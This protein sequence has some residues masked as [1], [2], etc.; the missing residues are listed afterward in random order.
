MSRPTLQFQREVV[1]RFKSVPEVQAIWLN[2]ENEHPGWRG[3]RFT[4]LVDP[5]GPDLALEAAQLREI[6]PDF[7]WDFYAPGELEEETIVIARQKLWERGELKPVLQQAREAFMEI[8]KV[9]D[10]TCSP[11]IVETG[12]RAFVTVVAR[13]GM[14]LPPPD[15]IN[16]V[17][18]ATRELRKKTP[19]IAEV[20]VA[21]ELNFPPTGIGVH[22]EDDPWLEVKGRVMQVVEPYRLVV[23]AWFLE[24][25]SEGANPTVY[26]YGDEVP[27]E[28][29]WDLGVGTQIVL[30]PTKDVPKAARCI[31]NPITRLMK[32]EAEGNKDE[33]ERIRRTIAAARE[34]PTS[35][36]EL[37]ELKEL[38]PADRDNPRTHYTH[39][40]WC[41]AV[42]PASTHPDHKNACYACD[43]LQ[44]ATMI[45][46]KCEE[47]PLVAMFMNPDGSLFFEFVGKPPV[48]GR[49]DLAPTRRYVVPATCCAEFPQ[50]PMGRVGFKKVGD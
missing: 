39:C 6:D 33:A 38:P 48:P 27:E 1:E 19:E 25:T 22:D 8:E 29:L 7:A 16:A 32:A 46:T 47:M 17:A 36:E 37:K 4:F 24:P 50:N 23:A 15:L 20:Q 12:G 45:P 34:K 21:P 14:G 30:N 40:R 18:A 42:I 9:V 26:V 28:K 31:F 13:V 43:A 2:E 35:V 10:V 49:L 5:L 11:D 44:A 3:H 41:G